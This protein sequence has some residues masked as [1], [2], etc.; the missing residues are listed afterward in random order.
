MARKRGRLGPEDKK[1]WAHVQASTNPM[2]RAKSLAT[3]VAETAAQKPNV[4]SKPR[5]TATEPP[6]PI[7]PFRLGEKARAFAPEPPRNQPRQ[8]SAVDRRAMTQMRRGRL[9]PEARI[10]LH[11]MTQAQALPALT[12]FIMRA[13]AD[14]RRMVLVITGKGRDNDEAGPIPVRRGIL[15]HNV[16]GWLRAGPMAGQVLD[17]LPAHQSHGGEGAYYIYLRRRR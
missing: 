15:R 10:D 13:L 1:L 3:L 14:D 17:V 7:R 9:R 5:S 8:G 16:P 12:G 4:K 2:H 6:E 11:G